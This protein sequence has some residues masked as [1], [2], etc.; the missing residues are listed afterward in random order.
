MRLRD[1]LPLMLCGFMQP[2]VPAFVP[3]S[4][5]AASNRAL[6]GRWLPSTATDRRLR[7]GDHQAHFDVVLNHS[8]PREHGRAQSAL[9]PTTTRIAA[10]VL[11]LR[12]AATE[13]ATIIFMAV[14]WSDDYVPSTDVAILPDLKNALEAA[15]APAACGGARMCV[16]IFC[17][18]FHAAAPDEAR[19]C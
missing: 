6:F 3:R 12:L 9:L 5:A 17:C 19:A 15:T 14:D 1:D 7:D 4:N 16:R 13:N 18:L 11:I 10:A 8:P 2:P